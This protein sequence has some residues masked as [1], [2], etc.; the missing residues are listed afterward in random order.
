[1]K[2][3]SLLIG[4]AALAAAPQ[5]QA[6]PQPSLART[7]AESAANVVPSNPEFVPFDLRRYGADA[8]GATPSDL[9]MTNALMV[10]GPSGGTIRAPGGHYKFARPINLDRR[11]S[12]IIAGDA[13][14]TSGSQSATRFTYTGA[15]NGAFISMNSAVGCQVRG[16]QMA[17]EDPQ[18]TGTYIQCGNSDPNHPA[19]MCAVLDCVLGASPGP[20]TTHLDLD[21]TIEF[22][23][24][25]CNF[26]FGNPS[27]RGRSAGGF[28][29]VI[30]FRDCQW[31]VSHA[32]PVQNGGQSWIFD[33]CAFEPLLSG[34]AG[35]LYSGNSA[36]AFN[37]LVVLGCWLG[38]ASTGGTWIDIYGNG[39]MVGGNY[40]SGNNH[41]PTGVALRQCVG[42][43]IAGNLFDNLL[44]GVDFAAGPCRDI[45]VQSN[46]AN[47]VATGFRN[48]ENVLTG[49]LVW[50]P[51]Y[52]FGGPGNNH[53]RIAATGYAADAAAGVVRQWGAEPIPGAK[54]SHLVSFPLKFPTEC[55]NVVA[56]LSGGG[57]AGTAYV[58]SFT[59]H[60]FEV[61]MVGG[62]D[63]GTLYWQALG[64]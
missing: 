33:G 19:F 32:T 1:M 39:V 2:R 28:S 53:Q 36:S 27:V 46:V 51:N 18:Y 3:R 37:G 10:C 12:I 23:A 4:P 17:H 29:N 43:Q 47:Q 22:T 41:G 55:L 15:G 60:S 49:S 48:G 14:G 21:K 45:V 24:E 8:S 26:I 40:I 13:A 57:N 58:S 7:A 20:G 54:L 62:G 64:N 31:S 61:T 5:L 11:R 44:V 50:G 59:P 25:R 30:R 9:A 34:A 56:T 52:G 6:Q 42:I 63:G 38:D 16:L 35:A